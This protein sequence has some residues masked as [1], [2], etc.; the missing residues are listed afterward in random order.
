MKM[1][2]IQFSIKTSVAAF[3]LATGVGCTY[4]VTVDHPYEGPIDFLQLFTG[5]LETVSTSP[6]TITWNTEDEVGIFAG[7]TSNKCFTLREN[8]NSSAVFE[9]KDETAIAGPINRIYAYSPY[10][11]NAEIID[12]ALVL[13]IPTTQPY[14]AGGTAA[15]MNPIVASAS[16]R[17]VFFKHVC[18]V[19]KLKLANPEFGKVK[20]VT[21]TTVEDTPLSGYGRVNLDFNLYEDPQFTFGDEPSKSVTVDCGDKPIQIT[22]GGSFFH[23]VVAPGTYETLVFTIE[24]TDG[25]IYES[26]IKEPLTVKR[27]QIADAGLARVYIEE[28]FY[29]KANCIQHAEPGTYTF[30][31]SPYFTTDSYG[32]AYE[33][34]TRDNL[35][36]ASS[37][38]LLWQSTQSMI[39]DL[40]LSEDKK[41]ITFTAAKQGNALVAIRDAEGTILWSFHLWISPVETVLYPNGYYVLDRNLGARSNTKGDMSSWGLYYQWGRKDPMPELMK[42]NATWWA[43]ATYYKMDNSDFRVDGIATGP[44]VDHYYAVKHPTTF[45]KKAG[46]TNVDWIYEGGNDRLWGNPEGHSKPDI[47]TLKKS[48]Y[49]PC[50]EGYMVSP[51]DL[52]SANGVTKG[53]LTNFPTYG[54]V[55]AATATD[56]GRTLTTNGIDQWYPAAR[57]YHNN[58]DLSPSPTGTSTKLT[59]HIIRLWTSAP[60]T[61]AND[62]KAHAFVFGMTEGATYPEHDVH[63]AF[64]YSI[65]CVK[66]MSGE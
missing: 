59:D 15:G 38:D 25:E 36:L 51:L 50:P 11:T 43:A 48:I 9:P 17:S 53:A 1:K 21:M 16:T 34:N 32:Y 46:S 26:R 40:A 10:D 7:E 62:R 60:N 64:G 41:S 30:D 4:D 18:G 33:F 20:K 39:T 5:N 54:G 35:A 13:N 37:A 29:G 28:F 61:T 22:M 57:Q 6:V 14:Q 63:R 8:M 52:F 65:R 42:G 3:L 56:S 23:F 27:G 44:G 66:V 31:V 49:D 45:I 47:K 58:M 24:N 55:P 2:T 12:N 19:V